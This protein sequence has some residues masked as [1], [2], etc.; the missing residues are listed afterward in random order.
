M[1]KYC[2]CMK[3]REIYETDYL[4]K[5]NESNNYSLRCPKSNCCGKVF[6]IDEEMIPIISTLLDKGYFTMYCC[7]GHIP[8]NLYAQI[9]IMIRGNLEFNNLINYAPPEGYTLKNFTSHDVINNK[10]ITIDAV[11]IER[12]VNYEENS[13]SERMKMLMEERLKLLKWVEDLPEGPGYYI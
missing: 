4:L 11:M 10:T 5:K 9:Y 8:E 7:Q 6:D 13:Y 3:C 12:I 2:M 1:N